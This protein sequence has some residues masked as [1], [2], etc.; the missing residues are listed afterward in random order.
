MFI[1]LIALPGNVKECWESTYCLYF[2]SNCSTFDCGA[3]NRLKRDMKHH[4]KPVEEILD[5][6]GILRRELRND[7]LR[8]VELQWLRAFARKVKARTGQWVLDRLKWHGFSAG[9]ETAIEGEDA[10]GRYSANWQAEFLVF[11]EELTWG[12][13]CQPGP[14]PDFTSLKADIYVCHHNMKWTMA[15]THEQPW[16][17]PYFCEPKQNL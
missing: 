14:Y 9:Y 6:G 10:L 3:P 11:D 12:F 15:F 13:R 8:A 5:A 7:E 16:D 2:D 1:K 4:K 17:G